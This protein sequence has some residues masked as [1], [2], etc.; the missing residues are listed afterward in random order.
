[1]VRYA[2]PPG[3]GCEH[4]AASRPVVPLASGCVGCLQE[5]T[6][7]VHL[8][9]CLGCGYVGCCDSSPRRH[10]RAHAAAD[11]HPLIASAEPGESWGY[12]FVDD[13]TVPAPA[14]AAPEAES[15]PASQ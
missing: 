3:S 9:T 12:C 11:D 5:G 7:W 2:W 1:M 4:G 13:V 10:A 15:S 6:E 8:R 14:G